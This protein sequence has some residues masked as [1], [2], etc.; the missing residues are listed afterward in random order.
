MDPR[1]VDT[2]QIF[3]AGFSFFGNPFDASAAWTEEN[4]IGRLWQR[5]FT[6]LGRYG[7][8]LKHAKQGVGYEVHLET[9]ET[10]VMGHF[11]VFVGM[12]ITQLAGVPV[13]MLV[14][15]LPASRYAVFTLTGNEIISDWPRQIYQEWLPASGYRAAHR[16]SFQW[17][18]HRF[19][20]MDNLAESTIEIY[21]PV[22]L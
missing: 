7:E 15:I 19:K 3:L 14:K 8:R 12:E 13:E 16:Y 5:L 18:D 17:Y 1:F 4:E 6:Y 21:V 20:G 11:E 22:T 2:G 10:A 9:D